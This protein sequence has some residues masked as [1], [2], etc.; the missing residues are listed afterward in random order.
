M[1]TGSYRRLWV[2]VMDSAGSTIAEVSNATMGTSWA[3]TAI[4]VNG[5]VSNNVTIWINATATSTTSVGEEICVAG[6]KLYM[7]YNTTTITTATLTPADRLNVTTIL[8]REPR[9]GSSKLVYC[10]HAHH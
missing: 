1:G 9:H 4:S 10:A 7:S 2:K 8:H 5:L 3:L 6:V